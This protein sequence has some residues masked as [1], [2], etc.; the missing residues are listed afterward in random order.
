[1]SGRFVFLPPPQ[2]VE[3]VEFDIDLGD[4]LDILPGE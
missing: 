4:V 1:L 2:K 3:D